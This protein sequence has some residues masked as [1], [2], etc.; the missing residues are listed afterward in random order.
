MEEVSQKEV[1]IRVAGLFAY[2]VASAFAS[3]LVSAYHEH[4]G[5][6]DSGCSVIDLPIPEFSSEITQVLVSMSAV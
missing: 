4:L 5:A 6:L 1:D 2:C 3:L